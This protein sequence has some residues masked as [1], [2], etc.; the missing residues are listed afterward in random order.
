MFKIQNEVAKVLAYMS[1][2]WR[3]DLDM[4]A[5]IPKQDANKYHH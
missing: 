3:V 4:I 2:E 5:G 1:I